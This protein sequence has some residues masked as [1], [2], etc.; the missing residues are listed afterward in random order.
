MI[1]TDLYVMVFIYS[2]VNAG[3]SSLVAAAKGHRSVTWM[4]AGFFFGIFALIAAVGLP[5]I[6][7]DCYKCGKRFRLLPAFCSDC[8]TDLRV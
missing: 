7:K 2:A 6:K 3:F 5:E 4:L 8:G 1:Q